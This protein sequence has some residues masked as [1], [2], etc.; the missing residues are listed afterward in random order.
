MLLQGITMAL[1]YYSIRSPQRVQSTYRPS[2]QYR[3]TMT[4]KIVDTLVQSKRFLY[5]VQYWFF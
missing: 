1:Q 5:A 3:Q 4:K 2:S